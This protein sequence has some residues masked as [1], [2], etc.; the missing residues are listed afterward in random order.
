[1]SSK[2]IPHIVTTMDVEFFSLQE[3]PQ[4]N[5]NGLFPTLQGHWA[6]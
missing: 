5:Y 3:I 6:A 4:V 1:M 2:V